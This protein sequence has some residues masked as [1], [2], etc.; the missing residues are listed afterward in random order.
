LIEKENIKKK[1]YDK[2]TAF[3][4]AQHYCAYQERSQQE[5]RN[6][7]YDWGLHNA[8]VEN[9]IVD[10]IEQNFIN[11]ERFAMLFAGGKFRIKKWGRIKI[12]NELKLRKITPYCIRKAIESIDDKEYIETLKELIEKKTALTK[13]KNKFKKFSKIANFI[14]SKGFEREL[15]I[16]LMKE[17][18]D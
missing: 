7:L 5:V 15:V 11:E 16:E 18:M 3:L 13:E 6:K 1:I 17:N 12:K 8:D 9:I 10:L 4:K 14:I 2:Q